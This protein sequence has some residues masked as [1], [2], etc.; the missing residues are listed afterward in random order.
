MH[1]TAVTALELGD[2]MEALMGKDKTYQEILKCDGILLVLPVRSMIGS[3]RYD[4]RE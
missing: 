4:E 2:S 1:S 3:V